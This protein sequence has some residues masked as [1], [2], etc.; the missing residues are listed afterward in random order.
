M[1]AFMPCEPAETFIDAATEN[2]IDFMLALCEGGP[3]G[4]EYDYFESDEEW[5]DSM[6]YRAKRGVKD[7]GMGTLGIQY[8]KKYEDPYPVIY[9]HR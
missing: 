5:L 3:H 9:N 1:L 6:I 7:N 4:D 8:L 2:K